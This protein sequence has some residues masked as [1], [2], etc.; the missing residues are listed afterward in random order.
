MSRRS[1]LAPAVVTDAAATAPN[2]LPDRTADVHDRAARMLAAAHAAQ[3]G[4]LSPSR[5]AEIAF[6]IGRQRPRDTTGTS[7]AA[8]RRYLAW[9]GEPPPDADERAALEDSLFTVN[10][11]PSSIK[12]PGEASPAEREHTAATIAA[13]WPD[14]APAHVA[15][16]ALA[17]EQTN[18]HPREINARDLIESLQGRELTTIDGYSARLP[19]YFAPSDL[20]PLLARLYVG[21]EIA[22]NLRDL[23][24][25]SGLIGAM[26]REVDGAVVLTDPVRIAIRDVERPDSARFEVVVAK[27]ARI[28]LTRLRPQ[29]QRFRQEVL[30]RYGQRCAMCA[31][32]AVEL[33]KAAHLVPVHAGGTYDVRNGLVLCANHHDALDAGLVA[34]EPASTRLVIRSDHNAAT[35]GITQLSLQHLSHLPHR[36]ALQ[37]LWHAS[38]QLGTAKLATDP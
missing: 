22:V 12:R 15:A 6:A 23:G 8:L 10:P 35:L 25:Q 9:S 14:F 29:Q 1:P 18:W 33:L 37:R 27:E 17:M 31:V 3:S 13:R 38:A 21:E 7:L 16:V 34:I 11:A 24:Y 5:F 26:L 32:T 30:A 19:R 36:D 20:A 2:P 28:G 4:Q